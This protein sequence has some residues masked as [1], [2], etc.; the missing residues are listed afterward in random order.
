MECE[1]NAEN[2]RK[3]NGNL[4]FYWE[5]ILA[6][7]IFIR[8]TER[9]L[10]RTLASQINS[11]NLFNEGKKFLPMIFNNVKITRS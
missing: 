7:Y 2:G 3:M 4:E 9:T 5:K 6:L 8:F 1:F 10:I 11:V